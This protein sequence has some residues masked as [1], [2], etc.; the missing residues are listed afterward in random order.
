MRNG[1]GVLERVS[2]APTVQHR[3]PKL[4]AFATL[5]FCIVACCPMG[6]RVPQRTEI[7]GRVLQGDP[8][9]EYIQFSKAG[10]DGV[11]T[12]FATTGF[13]ARAEFL[14]DLGR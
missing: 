14:K 1:V 8:M 11:F 2:G 6:S 7:P 5:R 9:A 13:A 3:N 4:E 10:I 12:D